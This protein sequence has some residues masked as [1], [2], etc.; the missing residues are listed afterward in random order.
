MYELEPEVDRDYQGLSTNAILARADDTLSSM[1]SLQEMLE[2]G[3]V[4]S[5]QWF[6]ISS[7]LM[8][9]QFQVDLIR[10]VVERDRPSKQ[11]RQ[12]LLES[13]LG[14]TPKVKA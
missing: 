14:T 1:E 5:M 4:D 8:D 2:V 11:V 10:R 7:F 13:Y 3:T 6:Y 9:L 12:I